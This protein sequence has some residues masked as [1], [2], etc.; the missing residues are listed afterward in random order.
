M[1]K[2]LEN[3]PP[4][5]RT[6]GG[7]QIVD[8]STPPRMLRGEDFL[9][10]TEAAEQIASLAYTGA[11]DAEIADYLELSVTVIRGKFGRQ[12]KR[13]RAAMHIGLRKKQIQLATLEDGDVRLLQFLGKHYLGQT[14]TTGDSS[15]AEPLK[16]YQNIRL[17]D[18]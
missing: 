8:K 7:D 2:I 5:V 1:T 13:G 9:R 12:L 17:E 16:T 6:T 4:K 15:G 14:D 3:P 11:T 18:V 10:D